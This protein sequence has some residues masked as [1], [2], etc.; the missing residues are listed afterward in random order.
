MGKDTQIF[1]RPPRYVVASLVC[2]VGELLQGIDTGIIGPATVMGSYVD[3]FGHPSPAVHGL[4]VSSMLLSA[5]VTSFLAGHV[6]DSLGRSSGIAI[7]G[8]VFAL[9]VVLEAG[10]VHLG[11]FIAGRLVVGVG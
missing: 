11:M 4:V 7:G 1:R 3:H 8:L 9:G 2:S 10:A 5:A 6:A